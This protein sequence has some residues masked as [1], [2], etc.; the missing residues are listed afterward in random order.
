MATILEYLVPLLSRADRMSM[1]SGVE[2]RLPFLD[3][4]IVRM[5]LN[6]PMGYKMGI[7]KQKIA[8]RAIGEKVLPRNTIRKKK[9][10][11]TVDYAK[12]YVTDHEVNHFPSLDRFLPSKELAEHL[13]SQNAYHKLLRFYSIDKL[14]GE[15][16]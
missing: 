14:C 11:F 5:A 13:I 16:L 9:V 2:M 8:L 6:M 1:A 15:F 4:D 10:G 3:I 7:R 12:R